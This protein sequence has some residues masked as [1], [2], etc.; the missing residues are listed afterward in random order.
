MSDTIEEPIKKERAKRAPWRYNE[1]GSYNNKPISKTYF[2]D[3]YHEKIAC[4]VECDLC[5]RIV[6]KQKL[7]RHK[8]TNVC[9]RYSEAKKLFD[10]PPTSD[11]EKC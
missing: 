5:G 8:R 2:R 3:Y 11:S 6:G 4:K 10:Q 9:A 7:D 1:D